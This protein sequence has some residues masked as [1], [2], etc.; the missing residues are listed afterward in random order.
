MNFSSFPTNS[1][2]FLPPFVPQ[3]NIDSAGIKRFV[4]L[5]AAFFFSGGA[6][7]QSGLKLLP[8]GESMCRQHY[9]Q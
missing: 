3:I 5:K 8:R 7:N 1:K 4:L 9:K 2:Y 6:F